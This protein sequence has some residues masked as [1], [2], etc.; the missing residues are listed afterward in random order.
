MSAEALIAEAGRDIAQLL[1]AEQQPL[2][3]QEVQ[4]V[5]R[6]HLSYYAADLGGADLE[7]RARL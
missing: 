6:H 4:E 1:R 7:E 3:P 5:L 2:S